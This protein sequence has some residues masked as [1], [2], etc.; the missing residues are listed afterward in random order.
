MSFARLIV[1]TV[2]VAD[3]PHVT[4]CCARVFCGKDA[5]RT[6]YPNGC[7]LCRARKFQFQPSAQHGETLAQLTI[8]CVCSE[9]IAP[10]DFDNHLSRCPR[11]TLVCPHKTCR[12]KVNYFRDEVSRRCGTSTLHR[13]IPRSTMRKH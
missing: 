9:Y 5:D 6:Q 3:N 12:E 10:D 2:G 8:Q 4:S 11:E 1:T 13:T 7:P